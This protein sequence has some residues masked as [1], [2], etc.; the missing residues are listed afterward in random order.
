MALGDFS[1][2]EACN[3]R[4]LLEEVFLCRSQGGKV[5]GWK[6]R[7]AHPPAATCSAFASASIK[8]SLACNLGS[9]T[10]TS[11]RGSSKRVSLSLS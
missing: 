7:A 11:N 5:L 3:V 8:T 10:N 9:L 2:D 1:T 6:Y 4:I